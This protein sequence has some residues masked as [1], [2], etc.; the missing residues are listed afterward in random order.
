MFQRF[1]LAA[2]LFFT[3]EKKPVNPDFSDNKPSPGT[4]VIVPPPPQQRRFIQMGGFLGAG[5][6]TEVGA[7][8]RWLR[9]RGIKPGVI[10]NDQGEGLIDTTLGRSG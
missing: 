3:Q 6:T 4:R 9:G 8:V 7:L 5:K 2:W 10:T 1:L